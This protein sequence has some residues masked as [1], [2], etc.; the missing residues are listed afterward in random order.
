MKVK[1]RR[2][3]FFNPPL[4]KGRAPAV[5]PISICNFK[6][7]VGEISLLANGSSLACMISFKLMDRAKENSAVS[8]E[9]G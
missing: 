9:R 6:Y 4:F 1:S 8:M 3:Y 5:F 7:L 2:Q